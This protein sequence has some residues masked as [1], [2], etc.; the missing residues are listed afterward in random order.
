MK[1]RRLR[2]TENYAERKRNEKG[3]AF[4]RIIKV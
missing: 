3:E 2:L 1:H 4:N